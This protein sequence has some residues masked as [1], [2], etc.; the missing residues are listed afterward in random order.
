M[1]EKTL[2]DLIDAAW[3]AL[4]GGSDEYREHKWTLDQGIAALREERDELR[5]RIAALEADLAECY[6]L[7][8]ADPDGNEDWRLAPQ[9]VRE[10][11]RLRQESDAA[12][13]RI[14][15]TVA[16]LESQ[17]KPEAG[18]DDYIGYDF[19]GLIAGQRG[20]K[21]AAADVLARLRGPAEGD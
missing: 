14:A 5:Q 7:T 19:T 3:R 6:R 11:T 10:V 4:Q 12:E 8:G 17:V 2:T 15:E 9:A 21:Q 18:I 20:Y 1:S 13:R 16:W